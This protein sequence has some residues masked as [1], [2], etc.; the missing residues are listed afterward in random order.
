M[1]EKRGGGSLD[2]ITFEG[3]LVVAHAVNAHEERMKR[4]LCMS[5]DIG[6]GIII[7]VLMRK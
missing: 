4:R 6:D 2:L 1:N 5:W 3:I 7:V